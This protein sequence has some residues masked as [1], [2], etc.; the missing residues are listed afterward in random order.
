M[1]LNDLKTAH[2]TPLENLEGISKNLA[3][4]DRSQDGENKIINY[5]FNN[6]NITPKYAVEFGA[7]SVGSARNPLE[8]ILPEFKWKRK[9]YRNGTAMIQWFNL[10]HNCECLFFEVNKGKINKSDPRFREMMKIEPINASNVNEIYKKYNVPEDLD[11]NIIDVDG[12]DFWIWKNLNYNAKV[13]LVEF[14]SFL[15]YE[16]SVTM[17]QDD[18]HW[19]WRDTNCAYFGASIE[20]FKRLGE[21]KGYS[22]VYRTKRNL[23]FVQNKYVKNSFDTKEIY[24]IQGCTENRQTFKNEQKWVEISLK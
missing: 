13:V 3:R 23:V 16:Q 20:A 11:I 17:H 5:I 6:L 15:G 2:S 10:L 19:E 18:N 21:S 12:Q 24:D 4:D 14:N 1:N 9:C 8:L 22:L 7:G